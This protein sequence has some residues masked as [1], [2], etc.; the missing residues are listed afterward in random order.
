M[1]AVFV[2]AIFFISCSDGLPGILSIKFSVLFFIMPRAPITTEIVLVLSF[3]IFV[4][5][6]SRSLYLER[7]W[8]SLKE[9]FLSAG[10]A[11]SIKIHVFSS[12]IFCAISGWFTSIFLSVL[13]VKVYRTVTSVFS[14]TAC[15]ACSYHFSVWGRLKFLHNICYMKLVPGP[16]LW[17][18][19]VLTIVGHSDTWWSTASSLCLSVSLSLSVSLCLCLSVSLCL[20]LSLSVSLYIV[21]N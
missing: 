1:W 9:M 11:T 19:S 21:W 7:F 20:S 14:V 15:D 3:H 10:T 16:F 8:N 13:I 4:T 12:N 17:R 2:S 5:S 18:Y 6:V